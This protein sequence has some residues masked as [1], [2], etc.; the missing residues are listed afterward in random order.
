MNR[1]LEACFPDG[2]ND[3]SDGI[4]ACGTPSAGGECPV[5]M[6]LPRHCSEQCARV[7][8]GWYA[9]CGHDNTHPMYPNWVW[10]GFATACEVALA[11]DAIQC[12]DDTGT[13]VASVPARQQC[14]GIC[15]CPN[16]CEDEGIHAR[17]MHPDAND[18]LLTCREAYG[19]STA[20]IPGGLGLNDAL[21]CPTPTQMT[22]GT[23]NHCVC[24][25]HQSIPV[26]WRC[27][28][29]PDCSLG[30]DE[31]DCDAV[32]TTILRRDFASTSANA[33]LSLY[34]FGSEPMF[35]V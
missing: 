23:E 8:L 28:G 10:D 32:L 3:A 15:D 13:R 5:P 2:D 21:S 12:E 7:F 31:A 18:D 11:P 34:A 26:E 24:R 30:E 9:G 1:M 22:A 6:R 20:A 35:V 25:N 29:E 19:P 33:D 17:A 14:D 4:D 16:F 27:D